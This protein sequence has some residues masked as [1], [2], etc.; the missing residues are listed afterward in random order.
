MQLEEKYSR[1]ATEGQG[2]AQ[3]SR[4][5]PYSMLVSQSEEKDKVKPSP[6][7]VGS[8]GTETREYLKEFKEQNY[9]E[10]VA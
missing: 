8:R 1:Q 7:F 2:R 9:L 5:S 3:S 10:T 4:K 6:S